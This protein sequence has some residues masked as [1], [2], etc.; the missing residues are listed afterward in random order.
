[1]TRFERLLARILPFS[2]KGVIHRFYL[3]RA[4]DTGRWGLFLHRIVASDAPEVF[5]NHPWDGV[6]FIFGS[7][8]EETPISA[9]RRVRFFNRIYRRKSHRVD[10]DK[11]TWTL[12]LHFKRQGPWGFHDRFARPVYFYVPEHE[13]D[14]SSEHGGSPWRG[15]DSSRPKE[16]QREE[17]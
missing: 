1:M 2:G 13:R 7:Y 12:F 5:H 16:D 11:P 10:I 15:P 6:S 8:L 4:G 14:G 3:R 17:S 9:P